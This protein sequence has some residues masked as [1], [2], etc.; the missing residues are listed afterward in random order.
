LIVAVII[1][2][3]FIVIQ[4]RPW[5]PA[6]KRVRTHGI[7]YP[8]SLFFPSS[9]GGG[10][11]GTAVAHSRNP[12]V[13][14]DPG[15]LQQQGH[16][17][18][19]K[20][21][22]SQLEDL[23]LPGGKRAR[24]SPSNARNYQDE[25]YGLM[26]QESYQHGYTTLQ[27]STTRTLQQH[28]PA[29]T[30]TGELAS[31]IRASDGL[32]PLGSEALSKMERV[33]R[34]SQHPMVN[35]QQPPQQHPYMHQQN[36]KRSFS[37]VEHSEYDQ[38]MMGGRGVGGVADK[39][40]QQESFVTTRNPL[41]GE[42][43]LHLAG[44]MNVGERAIR[45]LGGIVVADDGPNSSEK[46]LAILCLD[47]DGRSPLTASAATDGLET[48]TALFRLEREAVSCNR[49][50]ASAQAQPASGADAGISGE[51]PT[52]EARRRTRHI[53]SR[54]STP[55]MVSQKAGCSEVTKRLLDEGCSIQGVDETGRNLVHWAAA[56]NDASLLTRISHTKGFSRMLEA[57]D[58]YD[59]T[60]LMLA[61]RENSFEAA[62][63]LLEHRA[64]ID[65]SDYTDS[66]PLS[67]AESRGFSRIHALLLEYKQRRRPSNA[68]GSGSRHQTKNECPAPGSPTS[69]AN[70]D[71]EEATGSE[72]DTTRGGTDNAT[73]STQYTPQHY[74][75]SQISPQNDVPTTS[76]GG[77]SWHH[78][79]FC[80]D[81]IKPDPSVCSSG[82][83][84]MKQEDRISPQTP[85][86][87]SPPLM[88]PSSIK[89]I[90][91]PVASTPYWQQIH[92]QQTQQCGYMENYSAYNGGEPQFPAPF[93]ATTNE[94]ESNHHT[95]QRK[96]QQNQQP[97][98]QQSLTQLQSQPIATQHQPPQQQTLTQVSQH[99]QSQ[100][101]QQNGLCS[102]PRN[103]R[104]PV[105]IAGS[106]PSSRG[107]FAVQL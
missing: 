46:T 40:Q 91:P 103:G 41:N 20:T 67:E 49:S 66:C 37:T 100:A 102:T 17:P 4:R 13:A 96:Y 12:C 81:I 63:I 105:Y 2:L 86:T 31:T 95:Y 60:P 92:Q 50:A 69:S 106:Q 56:L 29:A 76:S 77:E 78:Q 9:G 6:R 32:H 72:V 93:P 47:K 104:A 65:V 19:G 26:P 97:Q 88:A 107:M 101:P 75:N 22:G 43:I 7:W 82:S 89:E 98:Q 15:I 80:N 44:R 8:P 33:I 74:Q 10:G 11:S 61:V 35:Q 39:I 5:K 85:S 71:D 24:Y 48:T 68:G 54:R 57:R 23:L 16:K 38:V 28:D 3:V 90:S 87:W 83:G 53:E 55:L 30:V 34:D 73:S 59:R 99:Q 27:S 51:K 36:L 52:N 79:A 21:D 14:N 45:R 64:E 70:S 1:L 18:G 25:Q 84:I 62:Q 42:T 94:Y 58:D